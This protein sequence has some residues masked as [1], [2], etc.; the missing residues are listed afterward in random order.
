MHLYFG[1]NSI[2]APDHGETCVLKREAGER[3]ALCPQRYVL[4][5]LASAIV[6]LS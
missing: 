1:K 6:T 5:H 4:E 3:P 2:F